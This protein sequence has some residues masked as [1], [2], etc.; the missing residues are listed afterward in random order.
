MVRPRQYVVDTTYAGGC[1]PDITVDTGLIVFLGKVLWRKKPEGKLALLDK[2][3]VRDAQLMLAA[4]VVCDGPL[5]GA[6]PIT[7]L[8]S[9]DAFHSSVCLVHC[10][11]LEVTLVIGDAAGGTAVDADRER[12]R[13]EV[14]GSVGVAGRTC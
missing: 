8:M 5:C 10:T 2:E 7:S 11:R 3:R 6:D 14:Q 12:V 4:R 9:T 1:S 13:V